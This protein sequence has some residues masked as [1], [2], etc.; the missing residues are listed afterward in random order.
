MLLPAAV[1]VLTL[2]LGA[3]ASLRFSADSDPPPA[4]VAEAV[5]EA[6]QP[7]DVVEAPSVPQPQLPVESVTVEPER[8]APQATVA[9][10][11]VPEA[12][13]PEFVVPEG[14]A[15]LIEALRR[16][17]LRP[18]SQA[19]IARWATAARASG[20]SI[21]TERL[22]GGAMDV[23][24]IEKDF[25]VPGRLTGAHAVIFVLDAGRPFPRGDLGHSLVLDVPS[26]S[27]IG[28]TCG[29]MLSR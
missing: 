20:Q 7:P 16:G 1:L 17:E 8:P 4:P 19:D 29:I 18:G 26:G 2:I 23:F 9:E 14:R 25:M 5:P 13:I 22:T 11:V 12:A 27:C 3:A 28:V 15:G 24:V 6:I 21:E 10:A